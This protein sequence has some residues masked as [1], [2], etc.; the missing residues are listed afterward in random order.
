MSEDEPRALEECQ[1]QVRRL[2]EENRELRRSASAFGHL[3]ERLNNTLQ[4]ERRFRAD[5]RAAPRPNTE[6]RTS[7]PD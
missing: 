7:Q 3:A 2:E 5:R 6:R 1:D 4:T